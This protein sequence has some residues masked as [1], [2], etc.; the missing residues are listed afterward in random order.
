MPGDF[1]EFQV[2]ATNGG[3]LDAMVDV[4]TEVID[5]DEEHGALPPY[6]KL[7]VTY[8]DGKAI[9]PKHLLK[10]ADFSTTPATPTKERVKVRIEFLTSVTPEQLAEIDENG[11][12]YSINIGLTYKQADASG[13]DPH[14]IFTLPQGKTK[15]TLELNDELCVKDQCFI[16][17]RYDGDNVV[18]LSKYNM[19]AG[20][21]FTRTSSSWTYQAVSTNEDGYGLQDSDYKSKVYPLVEGTVYRGSVVY[22][23]NEWRTSVPSGTTYPYDVYDNFFAGNW[24]SEPDLNREC[25]NNNGYCFG[26]EG[27]SVAYYVDLYRSKLSTAPYNVNMVNVRLLNKSEIENNFGCELWGECNGPIANTSFWLGTAKDTSITYVVDMVSTGGQYGASSY[28][29]QRVYGVRPVIVVN[30]NNL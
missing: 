30:K 15:D 5:D 26:T 18:L 21:N 24:V 8:V 29:T 22:S 6:V 16:F 2:D 20:V 23:Y 19:K 28:G 13:S 7:S 10:K 4:L 17:V 9:E 11:E 12:E 25:T 3:S 14:A 27:Y 1:Y